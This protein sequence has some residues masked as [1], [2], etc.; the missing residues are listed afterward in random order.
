MKASSDAG[1][2]EQDSLDY[3][4]QKLKEQ[5][6]KLGEN[7]VLLTTADE[8]TTA[9]LGANADGSVYMIPVFVTCVH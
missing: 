7:G 4:V 6:A 8:K 5:A 2:T 3:A 9:I 1:W